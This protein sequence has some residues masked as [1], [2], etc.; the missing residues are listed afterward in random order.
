[1]CG[2]GEGMHKGKLGCK[3]T[4]NYLMT[5]SA[6]SKFYSSLASGERRNSQNL[7]IHILKVSVHLKTFEVYLNELNSIYLFKLLRICTCIE[8]SKCLAA[9]SGDV[10]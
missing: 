4:L 5:P 6:C 3:V 1:M 7:G 10:F 9:V 8:S 2:E